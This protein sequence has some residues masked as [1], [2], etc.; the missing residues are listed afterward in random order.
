MSMFNKLFAISKLPFAAFCAELKQ[1]LRQSWKAE[2]NDAI[3]AFWEIVPLSQLL[4]LAVQYL[5][6]DCI[7]FDMLVQV[8]EF[9]KVQSIDDVENHKSELIALANWSAKHTGITIEIKPSTIAGAGYGLFATAPI[10]KSTAVAPYG[11]ASIAQ[12]VRLDDD[13]YALETPLGTTIDSRFGFRLCEMARWANGFPSGKTWTKASFILPNNCAFAVDRSESSDSDASQ[14]SQSICIATLVDI[15][16]GEELF[17]D[18][19][20]RYDWESCGYRR[21]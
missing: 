4:V 11:G 7:P 17:C 14:A 8:I 6:T 20:D 1:L 15:A 13:S 21:K 19:G 12:D 3:Y 16:Q 9:Y 2:P 5:D 18:Y 10:A